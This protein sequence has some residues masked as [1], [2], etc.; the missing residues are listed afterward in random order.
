LNASNPPDRLP[1]DLRPH[2]AEPWHAEAYAMVQVLI[3]TGRITPARWAEA[4]GAA[5]RKA[6]DDGTARNDDETYY[7]AFAQAMGQVLVADGRLREAD[8]EQR[9]EDWR[10][11]YHRTPHGTPVTLLGP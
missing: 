10:T 3:E 6:V 1:D 2:F 4:F 8:I 9:I 7:D 11:A 5:L